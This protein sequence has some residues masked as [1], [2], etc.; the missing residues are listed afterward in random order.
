MAFPDDIGLGRLHSPD[1]RD[2]KFLMATNLPTEA[3]KVTQKFYYT[4]P[5][6]DQG[7]TPHCVAFSHMQRL[8]SSPVIQKNI[9][10]DTTAIYNLAQTIDEWPGEDYDGTSVRAGA[11]AL[12]QL[13]YYER[14]YW[15]YDAVTVKNYLL[16]GQGTIIL[17]TNWFHDM[18]FPDKNGFVKLTGRLAGGHAYLCIGY[19][20]KRGA[21]R[22]VNSWGKDWGQAGRF[23]MLGEDV[24]K[25]I[26][27]A[28]E[29]C[30][31]IEIPHI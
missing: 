25:L 10:P 8:R 18:F 15:A 7:R 26:Q 21:F 31:P 22:F 5:V 6:L 4:K 30:L 28:G 14:Y 11:K 13:G 2:F 29:A 3:P 9:A 20:E 16:N 23:W 1:E 12:I 19:T 27:D 24:D 17:G